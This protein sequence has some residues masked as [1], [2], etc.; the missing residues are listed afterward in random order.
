VSDALNNDSRS[1]AREPFWGAVVRGY[2]NLGKGASVLILAAA[3]IAA[4]GA[5]VVYPLWFFATR[6]PEAYTVAVLLLVATTVCYLLGR[7]FVRARK[8]ADDGFK[9]PARTIVWTFLRLVSIAL[10]ALG[11]YVDI[12]IFQFGRIVPGVLLAA[13]LVV[14][15]GFVFSGFRR[16]GNRGPHAA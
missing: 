8:I 9:T 7:W 15:I 3:A 11:L 6:S 16:R 4:T 2:K 10:L 14:V 12:L 5:I 1:A 13:G